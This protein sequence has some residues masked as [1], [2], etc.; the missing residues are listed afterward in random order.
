MEFRFSSWFPVYELVGWRVVAE[1]PSHRV[2]RSGTGKLAR[3]LVLVLLLLGVAAGLLYERSK[4]LETAAP[5]SSDTDS[6][7]HFPLETGLSEA[8]LEGFR[9]RRE[10]QRSEAIAAFRAR[11]EMLGAVCAVASAVLAVIGLLAFLPLLFSRVSIRVEAG[12]LLICSG[13][14]GRRKRVLSTHDYA[15]IQ[16]GAEERA[17]RARNRS[18]VG[19]Y[20]VWFVRLCPAMQHGALSGLPVVFY[21]LQWAERPGA[22]PR[23]PEEVRGLVQF[24]YNGTRLPVEGPQWAELQLL[25]NG[26]VGTATVHTV[27]TAPFE[28]FRTERSIP[29]HQTPEALHSLA[30]GGMNMR[31][32]ND[33]TGTTYIIEDSTGREYRYNSPDEMPP[34]HR[35]FYD[36]VLKMDKQYR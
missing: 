6:T 36:L 35:T 32:I 27:A 1:G 33:G 17:I 2:Y 26:R 16:Y 23:P 29:L 22:Q 4:L 20:W 5:F 19:S 18:I 3:R 10:Q 21:P 15:C 30:S 12:V 24:L 28:V 31:R 7:W 8:E 25:P 34:A 13:V 9:Q 11:Q 14:L